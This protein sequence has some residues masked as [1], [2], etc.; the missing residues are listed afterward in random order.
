MRVSDPTRFLSEIVG[1]DGTFTMDEISDQIRNVIVQQVTQEIAG[2]GLAV[3][4]M[5]ANTR[6]LARLV[7]EAID[8]RFSAYG[9]TL[10]A[11]YIENISLPTEVQKALD[12]RTSDGLTGRG[13][14]R[15]R[16]RCHHRL[17]GREWHIAEAGEVHGPFSQVTM[18]R[19]ARDGRLTRDSH[20]WTSGQ[21]GWLRAGDVAGLAQLFGTR[22]RPPEPGG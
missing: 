15:R 4:D 5:A 19:M 18:Q 21:D 13:A 6:E 3:L 14:A 20:V 10:P 17:R 16:H 9:L 7:T 1:T 22:P 12:S 2:S 8:P 11:F